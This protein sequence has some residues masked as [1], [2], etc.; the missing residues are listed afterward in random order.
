[1]AGPLPLKFP[2]ASREEKAV[3]NMCEKENV[4]I[5][6]LQVGQTCPM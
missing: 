4:E 1:M 5:P 6:G 2:T 3:L